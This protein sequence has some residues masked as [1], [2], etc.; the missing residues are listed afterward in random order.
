[1]SQSLV[2]LLITKH[3]GEGKSFKTA[4]EA[5]KTIEKIIEEGNNDFENGDV[6]VFIYDGKKVTLRKNV[7][8]NGKK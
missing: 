4:T 5:F 7:R 6:I 2:N 1:M 8:T 3:V